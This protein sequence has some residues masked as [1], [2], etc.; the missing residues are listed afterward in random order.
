MRHRADLKQHRWRIFAAKFGMK[1][2]N[3]NITDFEQG[4]KSVLADIFPD[5]QHAAWSDKGLLSSKHSNAVLKCIGVK[6]AE[7]NCSGT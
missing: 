7:L 1:T 2:P 3:V 5:L 6:L 4:L